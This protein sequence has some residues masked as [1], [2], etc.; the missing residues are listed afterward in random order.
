MMGMIGGVRCRG[1]GGVDGG[2]CGWGW[3]RRVF[4]GIFEIYLTIIIDLR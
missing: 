1:W 2:W 4:I 3:G